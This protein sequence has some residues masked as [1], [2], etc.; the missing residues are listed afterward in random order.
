M[1][2]SQF[3]LNNYKSFAKT[4]PLRLCPGFNI[5]TG[6]N[7]VGK[8]ALLEA[9]SLHYVGNPHRSLRSVPFPDAQPLPLTEAY[10]TLTISND[11]LREILLTPES[12]F[13]VPL[14]DPA[15]DLARTIRFN[16]STGDGA[17][18]LG[19]WLL[20]QDQLNFEYKIHCAAGQNANLAQSRFPALNLIDAEGGPQLRITNR[21]YV[22]FT[23]APHHSLVA[24]AIAGTGES[25][26][27]GLAIG[28]RLYERVY[29]FHAQRL[30]VGKCAF[31]TNP[32]LASNAQ[33]LAEVLSIL[34]H[35]RDRFARLNQLVSQIIPQVNWISVR[36]AA[37]SEVE[38][39]VWNHDPRTQREDLAFP[40]DESG[41]GVGQILAILY[42]VLTTNS[43]RT[44]II[45]EPQ[46]FLHR[47]AAR[48]LVEIL[49]S[50]PQHQ[51][52]IATHSPT[53]ITATSPRTITLV[54]QQ[55]G[56]SN[57]KTLDATELEH[58]RLCLAEVGA[59]PAD[60]FGYDNILWVEGETEEACFPV[61]F[62]KIAKKSLMGTAI[63]RVKHTGDF[64]RRDANVIFDIYDRLS[65]GNSLL[66]PAIGFLFDDECRTKQQKEEM[67]RRGDNKV[68]FLPRRMYENYLLNPDAIAAVINATMSGNA[69]NYAGPPVMMSDVQQLLEEKNQDSQYFARAEGKTGQPNW[70]SYIHAG[71]VLRDLFSELS[72]DKAPVVF[73]KVRHATALT[74]WLIQN[75]PSDLSEVAN[76]I[77]GAL[78]SSSPEATRRVEAAP[79]RAHAA[80]RT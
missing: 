64:E 66:P 17:D 50:Y 51:Y 22:P 36:P 5:I 37:S 1:Y 16:R 14:P 70:L 19:S 65:H 24:E 31:G 79:A 59:T 6:Q 12:R 42:V 38:I 10:V 61:I 63:R 77:E 44:I 18:R 26:E 32:N 46:S 27:F 28:G 68:H 74:E 23:V 30:N 56:E 45:D 53:I 62:E 58:Q 7:N 76:A 78:Q 35:N 72:R 33:N 55:N 4:A 8:T 57:T 9:L 40:L 20:S 48:K 73:D 13:F 25:H 60:V 41:T 15:S 80:E 54:R 69:T 29:Y 21:L 47:G 43:P 39:V 11:E 71:N 49:K 2:I 3:Q 34:Q 75:A 67:K 52:I